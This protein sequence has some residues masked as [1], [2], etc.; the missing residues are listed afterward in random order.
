LLWR[1]L[2][3]SRA[4]AAVLG[5]AGVP[6]E[7]L[8][9]TEAGGLTGAESAGGLTTAEVE[10]TVLAAAEAGVEALTAAGVEAL[11]AAGPL[12][13]LGVEVWRARV[14]LGMT[15]GVG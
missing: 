13:L 3:F 2:F 8:A 15:I 11:T 12:L 1:V 6:T 9:T 5:A 4:G 14:L 10:A 7:A